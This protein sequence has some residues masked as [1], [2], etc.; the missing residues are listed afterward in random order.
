MADWNFEHTVK[1]GESQYSVSKKHNVSSR[2]LAKKN[3]LGL[4]D[5]LQI[6]QKLIVPNSGG[7]C[8]TQI[9]EEV[10]VEPETNSL[11]DRFWNTTSKSTNV[12][13]DNTFVAK[14]FYEFS[15]SKTNVVEET[16]DASV[17][18]G[19]K[20]GYLVC[21]GA[22]FFCNQSNAANS[23]G[24]AIPPIAITKTKKVVIA[25]SKLVITNKEVDQSSFNFGSCKP[26]N[27]GPCVPNI[28]WADF[29]ENIDIEKAGQKPLLSCSKGTCSTGGGTVEIGM[30]GQG[31]EV[32]AIMEE[33]TVGNPNL[34]MVNPMLDK[35]KL[36]NNKPYVD[37]VSAK[38]DNE[39]DICTE[40]KGKGIIKLEKKEKGKKITLTAKERYN[41]NQDLIHWMIYK[42]NGSKYEQYLNY[43][44]YGETFVLDTENLP[45][46]KYRIE[47]YG[48][49]SS[50][51]LS[52]TSIEIHHFKNKIE[53]LITLHGDNGLSNVLMEFEAKY[54]IDTKESHVLSW[55]VAEITEKGRTVLFNK[56]NNLL[57]QILTMYDNY[58]AKKDH[59]EASENILKATFSN[60]GNY[61]IT[62]FDKKNPLNKHTKKVKI[63][64]NLSIKSVIAD[65]ANVLRKT[66]SIKVRV[67]KKS[68][69]VNEHYVSGQVAYWYLQKDG[70]EI[71]KFKAISLDI[72]KKISDL[73][74][75]ANISNP[76]GKY[77]LEVYG[78]AKEGKKQFRGA[79]CYIF[80][81]AKNSVTNVSGI[82]K[83][84]PVGSSIKPTVQTVFSKLLENEKVVFEAKAEDISAGNIKINDDGSISVLKVG[85]Y[86]LTSYLTGGDSVDETKKKTFEINSVHIVFEKAL[87]AYSTGRKRWQTGFEESSYAFIDLKGVSK[88]RATIN[89][90]IQAPGKTLKEIISDEEKKYFLEK[91]QAMFDDEGKGQI[92]IN[93][94]KEY[95]EKIESIYTDKTNL[96]VPLFYTLSFDTKNRSIDLAEENKI[97]DTKGN[98][99][100]SVITKDNI[101]HFVVLDTNE[102][103][104]ITKQ[105][106][107]KSVVFSDESKSNISYGSTSSG[108]THAIWVHTTGMVGKEITI[109]IYE[110]VTCKESAE[111]FDSSTNKMVK[112]VEVKRIE[113][114]KISKKG[115]VETTFTV[116]EIDADTDYVDYTAVVYEK[117]KKD[118]KEVLKQ[119]DSGY[120]ETFVKKYI[121]PE[122]KQ[123]EIEIPTELSESPIEIK[124]MLS[125][126]LVC[127]TKL[128]AL[129]IAIE[130]EKVQK[131]PVLT[132]VAEIKR[133]NTSCSNCDS[134]ISLSQLKKLFPKA[135]SSELQGIV[136]AFNEN[137]IDFGMNSCL[138]KA[139]FFAQ[140]MV[141][142][143]TTLKI[144]NESLNYSST[145][146]KGFEYR[147]GTWVKGDVEKKL[148]G[149]YTGGGKKYKSPFSYFI[150]NK[151]KVDE[152]GRKDLNALGDG[153]VQSADQEGIANIVYADKNRGKGYKLGNTAEG[154][155]WKY[156]GRGL[157]QL[158]G[159][160]NYSKVNKYTKEILGLDILESPDQVGQPRGAAISSMGYWYMKG[161]HIIS[162]Y[163][164][165]SREVDGVSILVAT[166]KESY[167][168][169]RKAFVE[170]S[171]VFETAG[172]EIGAPVIGE[173]ERA[174]WIDVA[175]NEAI[176]SKGKMESE[177][178]LKYMIRGYHS[179]INNFTFSHKTAWCSSFVS[180]C[181]NQTSYKSTESAASQSYRKS[182]MEKIEGDKLVY[183]AIAVYT[184]YS[185]SEKGHVGFLVGKTKDGKYLILGGNQGGT[186][187]N[188]TQKITCMEMGETTKTKKLAGFFLPPG[189]KLTDADYLTDEELKYASSEEISKKFKIGVGSNS[190][191]TN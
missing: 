8:C 158:T 115:I 191:M 179:D 80:T 110:E 172:C 105:E 37:R 76:Y 124:E 30:H 97:K 47:P 5:H 135:N 107:V 70:V 157:I 91:K 163:L 185:N 9:L 71:T 125:K 109:V 33:R 75:E 7:N 89:V 57:G 40:V 48:R 56:E 23:K 100:P 78:K 65:S 170:S 160:S 150:K 95:N 138:N 25:E 61:E 178:P 121:D 49:S 154:D 28:V 12:A 63:V 102:R 6:G 174:P 173:I 131:V 164:N 122:A 45:E 2:E 165:D 155:G 112:A 62:V 27:N 147:D 88:L 116:P 52:S 13:I 84:I 20:T 86:T 168:K 11:M 111:S 42:L 51:R 59:F 73:I 190:D 66:D 74:S 18:K 31:S 85:K 177:N 151:S 119:L 16:V 114:K 3:N 189:Y 103:L 39:E 108:K 101:Q 148:T 146:L 141:E 29:Y 153:G 184:N 182:P 161:L 68:T 21:D 35:K 19:G 82:S 188:G 4:K 10:S 162:N 50:S 120:S 136:S 132:E 171:K 152:L 127:H 134:E 130:P 41:K 14:R 96:E 186:G 93:T 145:R 46:G 79:D 72:E 159:K 187:S 1:S 90:W 144:K 44:H 38:Y 60:K 175:V 83:N 143:G 113:N 176:K 67:N 118:D 43:L 126:Q 129:P 32:S 64:D 94:S 55:E 181:I 166:H 53:K 34:Y 117:I 156:R 137:Y 180:W 24:N 87:W 98:L 69:N 128:H 26:K 169:R 99:L 22:T 36:K 77:V 149:K 133:G 140:V 92:M 58:V 167:V 183:G 15:T 139:H 81:V 104:F 106:K 142:V 17:E 123:I 54:L